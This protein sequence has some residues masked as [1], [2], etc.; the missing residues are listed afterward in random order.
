[1]PWRSRAS[2]LTTENFCMRSLH[3]EADMRLVVATIDGSTS[4]RRSETSLA[5]LW[6]GDC[7]RKVVDGGGRWWKVVEGGG[8]WCWEPYQ[9]CIIMTTNESERMLVTVPK[10]SS[11]Q[12]SAA[13]YA[14][15]CGT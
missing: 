10:R 14:I 11:S 13:T 15:V 6:W 9:W 2:L 4:E 1:M 8:R 12:S 7:Q 3:S 5:Y